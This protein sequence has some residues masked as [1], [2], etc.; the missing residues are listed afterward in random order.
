MRKQSV[1]L[2]LFLFGAVTGVSMTQDRRT[3]RIHA[4]IDERVRASLPGHIKAA[5]QPQS[6]VGRADPSLALSHVTMMFNRTQEQQADLERLLQEQQNPSSPNY[7]LWLNPEEFADRFGLSAG[8][9]NKIS[10]WLQSKG[11]RIDEI[12]RSRSWIA[13]TGTVAQTESAFRTEIHNYIVDGVRH[14]GPAQEPSVPAALGSVVQG[15]RGLDD[16]RFKPRVK[17]RHA[18][19]TSNLSGN[20]YLVPADIWTIY[21]FKSVYGAGLD[22]TGQTIAIVG[23][24]DILLS[25]IRTFRGN[26][27][28]PANDPTIIL[29][30]GSPDPGFSSD[31]LAESD[32]DLEWA[33]AAAP[34]AQLIFVSSTDAFQS[35]FYSIDQQIAPVVSITYGGC[36]AD[37]TASD[38]N[39]LVAATQQANAQGMTLVAAAGDSGA[40]DCDSDF[41]DRRLAALGLTVDMPASLPY[42]TG[43]GGTTLYDV[44]NSKYWTTSN[45]SSGSGSALSYIPEVP[46]DDTL[47]FAETTLSGGGGGRSSLFLKPSWQQGPGV[48]PDG[49]R[50]VPDVALSASDHVGYLICSDG[51]CVNGF[52]A[53]DSTLFA[54]NGTSAGSP[55]FAGLVALLNQKMSAPQGNINPGL[56][57]L[58]ASAPTVFHDV[59]T[60]GNWMPCSPGSLNCPAMGFLGYP[61][62]R[63]YDLATGL[64]SVDAFKLVN[65]W[66]SVQP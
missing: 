41:P 57:S 10:S 7:H 58:A 39:M 30:P 56:Y 15:I 43:V 31:D 21:N 37:F 38:R 2:A 3:G 45:A 59:I 5:A 36:E 20:H 52:R 22:G 32:L 25:D 60:G 63:G 16:F 42:V 11:L 34:N 13:F 49:V 53:P 51:S 54:V 55:I 4:E 65:A 6:D 12:S 44:P 14:Y 1:V 29:V 33:G 62:T 8:D 40:A 24:T 17:A 19:F 61:A 26:A 18:N 35:L 46:W 50:D 64:G 27:A 48:P 47:V 9:V 28:L 66:P 23:Q